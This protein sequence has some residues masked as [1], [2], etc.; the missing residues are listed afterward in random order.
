MDNYNTTNKCIAVNDAC[1]GCMLCAYMCPR[2]CIASC[3]DNDGFIYP[4]VNQEECV[5]CG[6]CQTVCDSFKK[7]ERRTIHSG[8]IALGNHHVNSTSG[9]IFFE[10]A[11]E[12]ISGNGYVAGC[13]IDEN[14]KVRHILTNKLEDVKKMRGSKYVQSNIENIFGDV[15]E[16]ISNGNIV[17]F[18]GTPCQCAAIIELLGG[19]PSNLYLIDLVCHG[20]PSPL[21]WE[22]HIKK[23]C[24][25]YNIVPKN[26]YF[27]EKNKYEKT[28]YN[29]VLDSSKHSI[30]I[31]GN[32][33]PYMWQFIKENSYRESCY[34]CEYS[35]ENRLGDITIGD[36]A[37]WKF[38]MDFYPY[39]ATSSVFVNSEKGE[40]LWEKCINNKSIAYQELE[41]SREIMMNQALHKAPVRTKLRDEFYNDFYSL[42]EYDI[43]K[44]YTEKEKLGIKKIKKVIK[45][46]IPAKMREYI[47]KRFLKV[48]NR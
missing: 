10:L 7:H 44:K 38:Y 32:K 35:N 34:Q 19:H 9:G 26:I 46:I 11:K 41:C 45:R 36:C 13:I 31:S 2:G 21:A 14:F 8:Y 47:R 25:N 42:S 40:I 22:T 33:D 24:N 27:R 37:S 23:K 15:K 3:S 1:T 4:R 43:N 30:S 12:I 39:F 20:V 5:D 29:L 18:S 28:M 6:I 17:L 48:V 16:L